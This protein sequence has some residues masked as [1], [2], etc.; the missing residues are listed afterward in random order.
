MLGKVKVEIGK[1]MTAEQLAKLPEQAQ[2]S[3]KEKTGKGKKG[4]K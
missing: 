3:F 4:K 1:L 2:N